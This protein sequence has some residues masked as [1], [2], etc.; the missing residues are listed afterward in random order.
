M[1]SPIFKRTI[2]VGLCFT[3]FVC[4]ILALS[5][6][7]SK[8]TPHSNSNTPS[9]ATTIDMPLPMV[10]ASESNSSASSIIASETDSKPSPAKPVEA[11]RKSALAKAPETT[12]EEPKENWQV[13]KIREGDT[14]SKIFSR[15]NISTKD[16]H[17]IMTSKPS[18]KQLASL[19]PGQTLKLRVNSDRH[20]TG[21]T[22]EIAPGDALQVSR[23]EEGFEVE[24][25]VQPLE[26][27][28]AFGKGAIANSL[29]SS[30]KRAGLDHN[31]INQ[32]VKIFSWNIDFAL[33]LQPN[34][35]FR[36]LFE[37]KLLDG[38]KVQTGNILAA[39]IVNDG[40]KHQAVRYTDTKGITGY[41]SP[42]GHGMHQTFLRAPVNF[43]KISSHFG[44]RKHPILHRMRQHKGV[45][46]S[47]PH[48]TPV[49][50][51]GDGKVIFVGTRGGY[52][53]TVQL[54]H[55]SRYKTL[56]AHLSGFSR[57]LRS[58]AEV[59]QGQ[60]I[61]FVGKTGLATGTHLHYEFEADG[62]VHNPLTVTLPRKNPVAEQQKRHFLAHAKEMLRLLDLHEHKI[63]VAA[64]D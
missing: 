54:Q 10:D 50:A 9:L 24:H 12:E 22:L 26:K 49:Q 28:L 35:T 56:Y 33:D 64:A 43:V 29:I 46:Y 3:A 13:V 6:G 4:L 20:I 5:F 57:G 42:D 45:D 58:G 23:Y 16:L 18:S 14:L 32:M 52:G 34:D 39:E 25:K 59:K 15:L 53:K 36:V 31:I 2:H 1:G 30:G 44:S 17:E 60:I 61:G 37:E 27:Q 51:T 38:E 7:K 63:N 41:F 55:G 8:K 62:I 40:K 21:L 47:A 11:I 19:Q 48:G